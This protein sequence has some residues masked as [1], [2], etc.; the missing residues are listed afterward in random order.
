MKTVGIIGGLGPETTANFYLEAI[1]SAFERSHESRPPMF[2][3]NVPLPYKIE[4]DLIT[5]AEGEERYIPY[6]VDAA[7]RLEAGGADF[8]VIPCNSVH[9]FIEEIREAVKI[10]VLS[11]IEE[12]V[13]FLKKNKIEEVGILATS[14]TIRKKLYDDKLKENNITVQVPN[15][16]DQSKMGEI[17]NHLVQSKHNEQDKKELLQIIEDMSSNGVKTIILACTDLQLLVPQH[18]DVKIFDT[19]EILV[20]ATVREIFFRKI[21]LFDQVI[22]RESLEIKSFGQSTQKF[23]MHIMSGWFPSIRK[24]LSPEGVNK[25]RVIDRKNNKYKEKVVDAKT[26]RVIRDVEEKLTDHK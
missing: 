9:I 12:T 10:P 20:Q 23:F 14:A 13:D 7:K 16:K 5:K 22:V 17:I 3:W 18:K 25:E 2:I 15:Q 6:L 4:E 11:I 24:D 1:F 19:M 8:I 21:E 26:G